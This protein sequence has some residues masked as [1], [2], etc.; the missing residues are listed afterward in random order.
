MRHLLLSLL[1]DQKRLTGIRQY[2]EIAS[3]PNGKEQAQGELNELLREMVNVCDQYPYI[4]DEDKFK[5]IKARMTD[6]PEYY[7]LN[8]RFVR[9][10]LE[11]VKDIYWKEHSY[12]ETNKLIEHISNCEV[13]P[14]SEETQKLINEYM[15]ILATGTIKTVPNVNEHDLKVIQTE[16]EER[17]KP[18]AYSTTYKPLS[19]NEIKIRD[20][21]LQWICECVHPQT[22]FDHK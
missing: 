18:K 3:N 12:R 5:I 1:K 11:R 8:A 6:A 15:A 21:H 19:E 13:L 7:G 14:I 4:S 9:L 22:R 2:E 20:M 10:A 17:V 16:D